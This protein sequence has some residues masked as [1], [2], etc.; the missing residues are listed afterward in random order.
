MAHAS[1]WRFPSRT[2]ETICDPAYDAI[3]DPICDPAY[4]AIYKQSVD[5]GVGTG[6]PR[7]RGLR[8]STRGFG[9]G[10][11]TGGHPTARGGT[12][13]AAEPEPVADVD[14]WAGVIRDRYGDTA[15]DRVTNGRVG[16]LVLHS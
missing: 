2:T 4:D 10:T 16:G 5:G 8:C 6:A 11:A 14:D 9:T 13:S 7:C 15:A 3:Y 12:E 1:S